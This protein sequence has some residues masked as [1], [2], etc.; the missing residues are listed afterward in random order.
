VLNYLPRMTLWDLTPQPFCLVPPRS[1]LC[2]ADHETKLEGWATWQQTGHPIWR[3]FLAEL[4]KNHTS[5]ESTH[6]EGP[7]TSPRRTQH[8]LVSSLSFQ[9]TM[10]DHLGI[11]AQQPLAG[12]CL[13]PCPFPYSWVINPSIFFSCSFKFI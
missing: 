12:K 11:E 6:A 1:K 2:A 10:A 13:T 4:L 8:D 7:G 3:M 9:A 5:C